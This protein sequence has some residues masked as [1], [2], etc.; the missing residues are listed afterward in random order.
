MVKDHP[1][2]L[3]YGIER[4]DCLHYVLFLYLKEKVRK[5]SKQAYSLTVYA[6]WKHITQSPM[7]LRALTFIR[8][9]VG[10]V[11]CWEIFRAL[12]PD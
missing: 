9:F 2:F 8:F 1:I 4:N 11:F 12:I 7:N 10:T 3:F 5:R 6:Y